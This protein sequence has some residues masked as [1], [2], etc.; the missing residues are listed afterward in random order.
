MAIWRRVLT[1]F[2]VV[3]GS[4]VV[5]PA[6]SATIA[7]HVTLDQSTGTAAGSTRNLGMDLTFAPSG[8]DSPKDLTV[9][10]PAGLLAN[11]SI[12]GGECLKTTTPTAACQVGSGTVSASETL[13][14]I[15]VP[16]PV[17]LPVV[18]DLVAPPKP[19]DLAGLALSV[20]LLGSTSPLGSPADITVRPSSS[21][22]GVGLNMSFTDVPDTYMGLPISVDELNTTF[23]GLRLPASCPSSPANVTVSGDSYQDPTTRSASAPLHVTSCSA[24]PYAPAFKVTA[25]RDRSD[26]GVKVTTDITQRPGEAT[27]RTVALT[28]PAAVVGP[29]VTAVLNGGIL[30]S[31]P[32]LAG[33]KT[34]GSASSTSPLYPRKLTGRAYLTGSLAAPAITIVFPPPFSLQ[35]NGAVDLATNTT[36]FSHVPDIPLTDLGV[37]LAGGPDAVF[38]ASCAP[39]GG[40]ATSTLT[41]QNGDRT[42]R[43]SSNFTVAGCPGSTGGGGGGGSSAGG[44]GAGGA[45]GTSTARRPHRPRIVSAS[46]SGLL[47]GR[48]SLSFTLLAG[49]D[50][51]K[52]RS[53]AVGLPRG[54]SFVRRRAHGRLRLEGLSVTGAQVKSLALERGRL[55]VT[56]RRPVARLAVTLRSRALKESP[57]L[58]RRARQRRIKS[59]K[60]TVITTNVRGGTTT[61]TLLM[62]KLHL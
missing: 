35:L 39:A 49:S 6:A 19:G 52:L 47:R 23:N 43:V 45:S 29:N 15:P 22:A 57:G 60:L 62:R 32:T 7:P 24:L 48:P 27:S 10:L 25:A 13:L 50:A 40:T 30:C 28:L 20:S 5:A 9:S 2:A 16:V 17:S 38:A 41:S 14:G 18:F 3:I 54:L 44:S 42:R 4:A 26:S 36:T 34:I 58:E 21:P 31:N 53:F 11:A 56:L 33:C 1:G 46:L 61:L 55:V 12:D 51:P 59:L 8:S 37:T